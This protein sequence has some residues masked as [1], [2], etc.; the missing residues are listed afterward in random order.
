MCQL[1]ENNFI[2]VVS[3]TK[4]WNR[5]DFANFMATLG[6]KTAV[7]FDGGGSVAL[8]YKEPNKEIKTLT[9]NGRALSNIIYFIEL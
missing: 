3:H 9:G 8:F 5:Q 6:C 1:D 2:S 4:R 7:N